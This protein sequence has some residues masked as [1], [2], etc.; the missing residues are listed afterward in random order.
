MNAALVSD[1]CDYDQNEHNNEHYALFVRRELENPEQALHPSV[2]Q[3]TL[4][5]SGTPL[6]SPGFL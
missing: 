6:S 5:N 3:L 2:A 4:L 1:E